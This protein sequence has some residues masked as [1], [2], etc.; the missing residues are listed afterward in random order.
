MRNKPKHIAF[1]MDGNGR[2]AQSRGLPRS[3]GHKAGFENIPTILETCVNLGITTISIFIWSTENWSRPKPEVN[4]LMAALV[5][6]MPKFARSSIR[7]EV[8]LNLWIQ[9]AEF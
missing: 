3:L 8:E 2:W 5:K 1:I 7:E 6:N 4:Y 9:F